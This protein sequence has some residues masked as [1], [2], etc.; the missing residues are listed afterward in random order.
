M[1]NV[2]AVFSDTA[3]FLGNFHNCI[4]GTWGT[5][6]AE[7]SLTTLALSLTALMLNQRCLRWGWYDISGDG[8]CWRDISGVHC[9]RSF[10]CYPNILGRQLMQTGWFKNILLSWVALAMFENSSMLGE[11]FGKCTVTSTQRIQGGE[12]IK[13]GS[14]WLV[15]PDVLV[16]SSAL[17]SWNLTAVTRWQPWIAPKKKNPQKITS[18]SNI[19]ILKMYFQN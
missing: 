11:F 10:H 4:S 13:K 1:R 3:D 8:Y 14:G 12:N 2:S 15:G 6:D 18:I 5:A 9:P 19:K 17:A 7:F 16:L